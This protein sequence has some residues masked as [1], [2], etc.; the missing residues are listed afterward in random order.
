MTVLVLSHMFPHEADAGAGIFVLEQVKALRKLGVDVLVVAP[1]PWAPGWLKF[2]PGVRKYSVLT[3]RA[4]VEHQPVIRPAVPMLPKE[5]GYAALGTQFY[6]STRPL[7]RTLF[8]CY[9]IDVIHAHTLT[10][11]GFAAVLLGRDFHVPVVCTAHGSDVYYYPFLAKSTLW[12]TRWALRRFDRLIAVSHYLKDQAERLAGPREI[13]VIH[14]G[15][16]PTRF[17]PVSKEDARTKLG[18]DPA[19]KVI[20]FVGYLRAEK[21]VD[22]L[23][24]AVAARI[25]HDAIHASLVVVR[26]LERLLTRAVRTL[27][28]ERVNL[29]HAEQARQASD[30]VSQIKDFKDELRSARTEE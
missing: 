14:N 18:I 7:V 15:A 6:L 5:K 28:A 2:F 21:A 20:V 22:D 12:A 1:R 3:R 16:D 10:P 27:R 11:D 13:T 19:S 25:A 24:R 30:F 8:Q 17:V 9:D 4:K 26:F 23:L 29:M